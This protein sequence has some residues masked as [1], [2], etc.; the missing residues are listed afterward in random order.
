SHVVSGAT[1][2]DVA[3]AGYPDGTS[4]RYGRDPAG[5][6]ADWRDQGDFHRTATYNARGQILT[7]LNPTGGTT[8]WDYDPQGNLASC[9]DN[10]G[11]TVGYLYDGF[12]RLSQVN[13]P[14]GTNR[15]FTYDNLDALTVLRD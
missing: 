4:N 5:N 2:F 7:L 1:F 13:G 14:S 11:N 15:Q 6:V 12:D 8:T 3:T 9:R 10:A